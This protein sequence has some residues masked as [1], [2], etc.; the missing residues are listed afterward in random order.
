M[1]HTAG[2]IFSISFLLL[3][4]CGHAAFAQ[5]TV[6]TVPTKDTN[7]NKSNTGTWKNPEPKI[8]ITKLNSD[9]EYKPDTGLHT[10]QRRPFT[11]PWYR[12]LGNIGSP[13]ENLF[14][15]PENRLGPTLGYHTFDVYRYQVD[16]L[17]FYNTTRPYSSFTFQLGSKLEQMAH[18]MV[19]ENIN[20]G[21]NF[22]FEYRKINSPGYYKIQRTNHDN[23][24]F[25][26]NYQSKNKHYKIYG[27]LVYNKQQYDENGGIVYDK[28]LDSADFKNHKT[29]DVRFANDGYSTTR[30]AVTTLQRDFT[31]L[32]QHSYAFGL[33]DTTYNADSTHYT[34][35]LIPRFGLTHKMELSTEK[36]QYKDLRPDSNWYANLFQHHFNVSAFDSVFTQQKWF[37]IDNRF[38]LN[39]FLGQPGKQLIFSAGAGNR[40]DQ[41]TTSYAIGSNKDN[42]ISNYLIGEL[43]KE[44][45]RPGQWYYQG[46]AQLFL[47]GNAAGDFL[48]N[49][50]AG[51][52]LGKNWGS[53]TAGFRQ[54]LN[55]APYNYTIY[56]NQYY[57][58]TN[59]Y[60]KESI[61]QAYIMLESPK[62]RFSG[63]AREYLVG[64]YIYLDA[65]QQFNQYSSTFSLSQ[66][67]VRKLFKIGNIYL[68]NELT[69][70]QL[71]AGAPVN[72]PAV[73][74]RHQLSIESDLFN[75]A[76]RTA[77]GIELRY[78][79][80]YYGAGYD[81]FFNRFYY[82][83][84]YY[85]ANKPELS[86]FFNFRI[87]RFRAYVMGDQL[88]QLFVRNTI[89]AQ[90]YPTQDAMLRFG[91]TWVLIN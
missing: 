60:S 16:S 32:F 35:T 21:W 76:L 23:L 81:P 36:Y 69:F 4:F 7:A 39:G 67:W 58:D 55:S 74:G 64:N 54:Q 40:Y 13:V 22:S 10:Y 31:L 8:I 79:T 83:N 37:W 2:T 73:L 87:K 30:S 26:T 11:Q 90:G 80:S 75:R 42:I 86:V 56:Q 20:P 50:F 88:Q 57:K 46:N 63:G 89:A 51:K 43:K 5:S 66:L 61:T 49:A 3:L 15:T 25:T 53:I 62:L 34:A 84:S 59:S 27:A 29:L 44:A 78:H 9:K 17:N 48:L 12:D 41:F 28:E 19:T 70:Q 38:L 65:T 45:L 82:Q 33:I 47:T 91:F 6:P 77:T 72:V 85:I 68:D 18:I 52:D 24:N 71:Q 1:R 14:F